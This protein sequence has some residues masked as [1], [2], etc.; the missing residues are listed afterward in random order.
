MVGPPAH[1][2]SVDTIDE[3]WEA[4][5]TLYPGILAGESVDPTIP[6][7]DALDD[8]THSSP[9]QSVLFR[10]V[11]LREDDV[12]LGAF[13]GRFLVLDLALAP[14]ALLLHAVFPYVA[15]A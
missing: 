3:F 1:D 12:A 9:S 4:V 7:G 11:P 10:V 14:A 5:G 6:V 2:D 8:L 15:L 13:L